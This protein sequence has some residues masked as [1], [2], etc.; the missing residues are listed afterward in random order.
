MVQSVT[1]IKLQL[2][3]TQS[4]EDFYSVITKKGRRLG[5]LDRDMLF[6]FIEGLLPSLAFFVR[7]GM[8]TSLKAVLIFAKSGETAGYHMNFPGS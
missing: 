4:L 1:F 6:Q 5:K 2:G 3:A 8:A 7:A